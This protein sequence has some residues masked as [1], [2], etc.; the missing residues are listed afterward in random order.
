MAPHLFFKINV[1][2]QRSPIRRTCV[3]T[4][5]I[6]H[7]SLLLHFKP[8]VNELDRH[9][10][11]LY[12]RSLKLEEPDRKWKNVDIHC[13]LAAYN[14]RDSD[15]WTTTDASGSHLEWLRLPYLR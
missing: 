13:C 3:L 5:N 6:N 15:S 12:L 10:T 7:A 4:A 2:M 8:P 14:H 1:L 9:K 11:S